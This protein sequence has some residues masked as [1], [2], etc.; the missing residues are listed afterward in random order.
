MGNCETRN[1]GFVLFTALIVVLVL[2]VIETI[3]VSLVLDDSMQLN[4][5]KA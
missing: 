4:R 5:A 3:V 1:G 2:S